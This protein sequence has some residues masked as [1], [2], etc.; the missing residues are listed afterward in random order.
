[1]CA[2]ELLTV[3]WKST[4]DAHGMGIESPL[5]AFSQSRGRTV[6]L[7]AATLRVVQLDST[8]RV[9]T[10][11]G[12]RGEGPSEFLSVSNI[13]PMGTDTVGVW[14]P[15]LRRL[16]VFDERLRLVF[17]SVL[18]AW[19]GAP[20]LRVIGRLRSGEFV[21]YSVKEATERSETTDLSHNVVTVV[22]GDLARMPAP[23][24][25]LAGERHCFRRFYL[26]Q[27]L[28]SA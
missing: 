24:V 5:F 9:L 11:V 17:A 10:S 12:G 6:A 7:D 18:R 8:G 23:V 14:D 20:A 28:Q 1:M 13:F 26:R 2:I 16:S 3:Q 4:E 19:S 25:S 22:R 27:R 21:G 15:Q